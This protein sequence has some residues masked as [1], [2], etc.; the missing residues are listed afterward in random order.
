MRFFDNPLVN[1]R[2]LFAIESRNEDNKLT[3]MVRVLACMCY[4]LNIVFASA[5][6][7]VVAETLTETR[8]GGLGESDAEIIASEFQAMEKV[9]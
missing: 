1:L 8:G 3:S 9:K 4:K 5:F 2:V 6:T 7:F